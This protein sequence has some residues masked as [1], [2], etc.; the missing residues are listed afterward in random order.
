[1][2]PNLP[3]VEQRVV[4]LKKDTPPLEMPEIFAL[5]ERLPQ[6]RLEKNQGINQLVRFYEFADSTEAVTFS[7]FITAMADSVN[8]HPVQQIAE[9]LLTMRWWTH[10]IKGLHLNDFI[11][12]ARC[13]ELYRDN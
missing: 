6:W 2:R 4:T 5:L 13:D 3:L 8:H 9:N 12:A 10:S 11:M 1:M 7:Q